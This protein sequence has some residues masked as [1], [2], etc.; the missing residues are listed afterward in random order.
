MNTK[1]ISAGIIDLLISA[2]VQ[3]LLV[4]V[5]VILPMINGVLEPAQVVQ[6]MLILTIC[7]MSYLIFRDSLFKRSIGKRVL[8][9]KLQQVDSKSE[10]TFGQ[11]FVRNIFWLLGPVE[12]IFYLIKGTTLG[13]KVSKTRIL[14][15]TMD[16]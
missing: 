2:I 14:P 1:R 5:F 9:L 6:R 10:A 12:M 8:K 3:G 4:S 11:R 7:S 13:E 15:I 16:K